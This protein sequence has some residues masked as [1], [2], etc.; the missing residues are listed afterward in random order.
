MSNGITGTNLSFYGNHGI[1]TEDPGTL[2]ISRT[3]MASC[4]GVFKIIKAKYLQ[5]YPIGASHPV[6]TFMTL[7]SSEIS[8]KG[9][10]AVQTANFTGVQAQYDDL[11]PTYELVV[12]LSEEPIETHPKFK[13]DIGGT[14]TAPLNGAMFEDQQT[15]IIVFDGSDTSAATDDGYMFKGFMV[16]NADGTLNEFAKVEHY[17]EASQLTW[18]RTTARKVSATSVSTVGK[19]ATPK[20][21]YPTLPSGRTWL[22]MGLTQ[23]QKGS[24]YQVVEEWRASGRRGWNDDIYGASS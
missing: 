22:Y 2:K 3:G 4:T 6:F 19:K 20:G 1:V 5:L 11:S 14:P 9:A 16:I 17:L 12:G 8:L 21:P 13:T 15:K 24:V 18:R 23:T 7:E 10:F